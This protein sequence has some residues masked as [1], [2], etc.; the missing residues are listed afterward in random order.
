MKRRMLA[1]LVLILLVPAVHSS[2]I[3]SL[4]VYVSPSDR[5]S[6]LIYNI[7]FYEAQP[8]VSI[9]TYYN[10]YGVRAEA[11]GRSVQC[12]LSENA[13]GSSIICN[14][15]NSKNIVITFQTNS[16][17]T[18]S[19]GVYILKFG[20]PITD[21]INHTYVK[22]DLPKG[23]IISGR[24]NDSYY[25]PSGVIGSSGRTI[26][27]S[28]SVDRPQIGEYLRFYVYYEPASKTNFIYAIVALLVLAILVV[29]IYISRS[30]S[31]MILTALSSDEKR[32]MEMILK[33]KNI[34]QRDI[35]RETGFSKAKVSRILKT[36][37]ERGLIKRERRGRKSKIKLVNFWVR[38]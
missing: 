21:L 38:R 31:K 25:P 10:V 27:V 33:N 37:E 8:T 1:L 9:V 23:Y 4:D 32:V 35:V 13:V 22:V 19:G 17:I 16:L 11:D 26:Y 2:M 15:V 3:R 24:V 5:R 36:F 34:Y 6:S 29:I 12:S 7:T 30:R 18:S 14:G 20:I 28:W